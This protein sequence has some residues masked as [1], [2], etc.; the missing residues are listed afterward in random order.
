MIEI[1]IVLGQ[2]IS[3]Y[4]SLIHL[5]RALMSHVVPHLHP[6]E[7]LGIPSDTRDNL[8]NEEWARTCV[9]QQR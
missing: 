7:Q 1:I 6:D 4:S 3:Y 2:M 9:L 8:N 5:I